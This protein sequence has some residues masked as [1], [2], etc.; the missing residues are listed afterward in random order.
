MNMAK[1]KQKSNTE[2]YLTLKTDLKTGEYHRM[3]VFYGEE[4]YLRENYRRQLREKLVAGPAEDFNYH[5][6][7][8]EEWDVDSFSEA[9]ESIP[10]MSE[11]S[12]VEVVDVDP[13]SR[14]E[15]ERQKLAALF[16]SLPEYCVILYVYDVLEW[17]PDKRMKKLWE[18][19]DKAALAVE[20]A[21]QEERQL[22][23]WMQRHLAAGQKSMP[24]ELARY[25]I[26]Q[27]GGSMTI[28]AAELQKLIYYTD[29]Q[30]I[31][32]N[33]V[34]AVVIPVMEAAVFDI[35]REIGRKNFDSAL[36]KLRDLL[37]QDVEPIVINGVIGRHL[38]QLY[39]AKV[40]SD[41]GKGPFELERLYGI[42]DFAAREIYNQA[43]GFKKPVLKQAMLESA[44]TDYAM[45]TSGGDSSEML[46]LMV[47]RLAE[48]VKG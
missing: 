24:E 41:S 34:D 43:R 42:R 23:R 5:R 40:L 27:T 25:L 18:P 3:Y 37:R 44:R 35:T 29:Q 21:R 14:P 17:K 1:G 16:E 28:L 15:S 4:D 46:E 9:V 38:R 8:E 39:S 19:M 45:K 10:M 30:V 36:Q 26:L 2:G 12:L 6:F 22:L 48:A 20:F 11:Y 31:T 47:L 33:D 32:K 13:F 7:T